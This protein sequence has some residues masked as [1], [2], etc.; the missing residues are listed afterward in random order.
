MKLINEN[1]RGA[2]V[3]ATLRYPLNGKVSVFAS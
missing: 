2:M 3:W 1:F